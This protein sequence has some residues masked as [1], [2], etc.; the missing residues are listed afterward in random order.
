MKDLLT[1]NLDFKEIKNIT[2]PADFSYDNQVGLWRSKNE[3]FIHST[4]FAYTATKKRDME[5]GE[6][7]K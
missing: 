1:K 4:E 3:L 7:Q 6:D 5:T 2:V